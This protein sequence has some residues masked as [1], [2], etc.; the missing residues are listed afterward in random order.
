MKHTIVSVAKDL[1]LAPSTVS[2]VINNTGSIS[3]ETRNRVLDYVNE[4]GFVPNSSARILKS[5]RSYLIGLIYSDISLEG[6]E[7]P[8]FAG[9][10]QSFNNT[11]QEKG[12]ETAFAAT[13]IG[14]R[15]LSYLEWCRNKQVDGVLIVSGNINN[16]MI[17]ELVKSEIPCVS[18]DILMDKL[19]TII[20]NN[21]QGMEMIMNYALKSYKNIYYV[22]GPHTSYSFNERLL[23]YIEIMK[24]N[25][26]EAIY[27]VSEGFNIEHGEEV[28]L[29]ILKRGLPDC[30]ICGSDILAIGVIKTLE[31]N[32]IR[33]PKDVSVIGFDDINLAGIY[34]PSLT[35]IRQD[36]KK[37]GK[38]AAEELINIIE[39]KEKKTT[40]VVR[41][42][43]ELIKRSSTTNA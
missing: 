5:R 17:K 34:S 2:K 32:N 35:T 6:L 11:L 18:T 10:L 40:K 38:L 23:K 13:K 19:T 20:S 43:V 42:P 37:I 28:A 1:G 4:I 9:I 27:E 25:N 7:H 14:N 29:R 15:S 21:D 3:E 8:F 24:K 30:I 12:Y 39:N 22:S 16:K 26:K 41:V 31:K 33:V 36:R